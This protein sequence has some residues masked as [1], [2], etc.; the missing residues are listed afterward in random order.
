MKKSE[1]KRE[2]IAAIEEG[3]NDLLKKMY[4]LLKKH[5][6]PKTGLYRLIYSSARKESCD[7][8]CVQDILSSSRKNN[9]PLDITGMLLHT[10]RRFLQILE[11]PYEN[12]NSLYD[13]IKEDSRHGGSQLRVC[14]PIKE[15]IFG[16]WT[17]AY[18]SID[19]DDVVFQT[20]LSSEK[21]QLYRSMMEGE[22]DSYTDD[23]M[24]VLRS[25][26]MVN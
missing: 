3:D 8:E 6:D 17:M 21:A 22:L 18:R 26:L 23:S 15:R 25:F 7:K 10:D 5:R 16:E 13:K 24:K 9:P 20:E 19:F 4:A 14:Q 1:V 11:G 12:I 2:L